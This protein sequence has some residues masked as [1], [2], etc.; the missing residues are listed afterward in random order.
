MATPDEIQKFLQDFKSKRSIW[1]IIFRDDRG[2]NAQALLDLEITPI[3]RET[4]LKDL[5]IVDYCEG[6]TKERLNNGSDMWVFGRIINKREIYIKI[7]FGFAGAQ[8]IC[9][10][11][12][13]AEHAMK[14]PFKK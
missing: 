6:P 14:Y 1:G 4:V 12:H 2:K 10:S 3:F 8:V 13:V 11:F 7:T 5:Q 9:I